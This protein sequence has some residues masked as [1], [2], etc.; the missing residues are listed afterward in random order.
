[1][2]VTDTLQ[3]RYQRSCLAPIRSYQAMVNEQHIGCATTYSDV[4]GGFLL[5]HNGYLVN[6]S[7]HGRAVH[8]D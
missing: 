7:F 1:M 6:S 3:D 4:D 5:S 8:R 2:H